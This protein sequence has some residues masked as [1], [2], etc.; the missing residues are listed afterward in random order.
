[1]SLLERASGQVFGVETLA[2]SRTLS[3]MPL[4][5]QMIKSNESRSVASNL[6]QFGWSSKVLNQAREIK[7]GFGGSR[8]HGGMNACT[9]PCA[10]VILSEIDAG[11]SSCCHDCS[12]NGC[13]GCIVEASRQDKQPLRGSCL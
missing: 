9:Q 3:R 13:S 7:G 4:S 5:M 2:S 10:R 1:M 12:P 8:Q 11:L 6:I